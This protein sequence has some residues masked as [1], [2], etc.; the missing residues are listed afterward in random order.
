MTNN[1]VVN[2][3][4]LNTDNVFKVELENGRVG[5]GYLNKIIKPDDYISDNFYQSVKNNI[6]TNYN[7]SIQSI[8]VNEIIDNTSY[9]IFS[10]NID[11]LFM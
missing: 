7:N 3:F 11:K 10:Q 9:E 8:I 5:I 2:I 1:T 4:E 6:Q